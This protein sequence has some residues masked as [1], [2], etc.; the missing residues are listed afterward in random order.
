[1]I[2]YTQERYQFVVIPKKFEDFKKENPYGLSSSINYLLKKKNIQ[3]FYQDEYNYN[4]H[5]PCNGLKAVIKNTS[6]L[7]KNKI[8]FVLENCNGKEVYSAEG[9]GKSKEF[10]AGYTEALEQAIA[11]LQMLPYKDDGTQYKSVEIIRTA[12]PQ[13]PTQ[14]IIETTDEYEAENLY[15]NNTYMLDLVEENSKK[16]L[17]I[18]NGELLGYKKLQ[19]IALLSPS[20]I[21]DDTYL[22]QWFTPDGQS[23]NG[24]AKFFGK[25]LQISLPSD[26]GNKLIKVKKP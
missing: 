4:I 20:G 22:I 13:K 3:S 18:I 11:Q 6:S 21:D 14:K 2:S 15:L 12:T 8:R 23:I 9:K 19:N 7:V 24:I 1:M 5:I 16:Y 26:R 25:E 10:K 17:K